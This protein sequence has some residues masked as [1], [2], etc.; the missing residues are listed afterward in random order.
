M[1][2]LNWVLGSVAAVLWIGPVTWYFWD[3]IRRY[4]L[5]RDTWFRRD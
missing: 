2:T 5:R 1:N 3:D 4:R